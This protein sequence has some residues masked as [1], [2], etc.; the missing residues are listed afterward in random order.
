MK[1]ERKKEDSPNEGVLNLAANR[2]AYVSIKIEVYREKLDGTYNSTA[3]AL[4]T[5]D[6]CG[7]THKS[8]LQRVSSE[9]LNVLK[10]DG[11][12]LKDEYQVST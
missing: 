8:A 5:S 9:E 12:T 11:R 7:D 1:K 3:D 10:P 6:N 4:I 2:N